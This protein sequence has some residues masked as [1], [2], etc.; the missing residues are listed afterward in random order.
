MTYYASA[1]STSA[2]DNTLPIRFQERLVS[3]RV[4]VILTEKLDPTWGAPAG[5]SAEAPLLPDLDMQSPLNKVD[6]WQIFRPQSS[7]VSDIEEQLSNMLR[8]LNTND[9]HFDAFDDLEDIMGDLPEP[10]VE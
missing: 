2:L 6:S 1:S 7:F 9:L 5:A 8:G 4:F 3:S 10:A